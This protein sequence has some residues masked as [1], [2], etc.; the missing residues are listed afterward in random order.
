[1]KFVGEERS[2]SEVRR[3]KKTEKDKTR[4]ED[5]EKKE[6]RE[7]RVRRRGERKATEI[8]E[9]NAKG[10]NGDKIVH[11]DRLYVCISSNIHIIITRPTE[12]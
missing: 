3:K 9:L 2:R 5:G 1:M 7:G 12:D 4:G 11:S 10:Y 8:L 6:D